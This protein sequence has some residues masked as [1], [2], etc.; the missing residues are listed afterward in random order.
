MLRIAARTNVGRC[1]EINEDTYSVSDLGIAGS[2]FS[3]VRSSLGAR[4]IVIGVYDGCGGA[5]P[6]NVAS[7]LAART[8]SAAAPALASSES[9][10]A[11]STHLVAAVR[12]AGQA[13]FSTSRTDPSHRGMGT[14]ATVAVVLEQ[15]VAMV[16]VGDTRA[17]LFRDNQ[18]A[19]LTRDDTLVNDLL[20]NGELSPE[21][22]P[23]FPHRNVITRA[24]GVTEDVRVREFSMRLLTGDTLLFCTDGITTMVDDAHIAS[25]LSRSEDPVALCDLLIEAAEDAGGHDN[26][27]VLI[28]QFSLDTKGSS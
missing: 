24:L 27:T 17:Y 23:S 18:L 11:A 25:I 21:E 20:D 4:A 10:E 7:H 2:S 14:T 3:G 6:G 13:I 9:I 28:A 26:E 16:H 1:R 15:D 8:I 12:A 19:Q 22:L 5:G